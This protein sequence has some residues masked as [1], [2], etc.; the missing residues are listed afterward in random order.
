MNQFLL[1][2][3]LTNENK[4]NMELDEFKVETYDV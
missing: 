3:C 2:Y 1:M 4:I